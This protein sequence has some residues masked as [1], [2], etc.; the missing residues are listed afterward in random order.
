MDK[1]FVRNVEIY[2]KWGSSEGPAPAGAS[3]Q[4]ADTASLLDYESDEH[5]ETKTLRVLLY[6]RWNKQGDPRFCLSFVGGTD[7]HKGEPGNAEEKSCGTEMMMQYRGS[8]T[9]IAAPS[10][11][12]ASLWTGLWNRHTLAATTGPS[13]LALLVAAE[14]GGQHALMGERVKHDGTVRLRALADEGTEELEV[15]LDGCLHQTIPGSSA[16]LEIALPAGRH[17]I[18]VRAIKQDAGSLRSQSWSSPIYFSSKG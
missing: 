7:N 17:Y 5:D 8:V 2:S 14:A 1:D 6:N 3:C 10:L 9:G 13:R 15:I 12:R 18:Y 4:Q 11:S 16:D